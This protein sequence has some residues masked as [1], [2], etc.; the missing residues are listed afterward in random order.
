[1]TQNLTYFRFV[2]KYLGNIFLLSIITQN[3]RIIILP[4]STSTFG[5]KRTLLFT[6]MIIHEEL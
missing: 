1:M 4:L 3:K 6:L 5:Q 2:H